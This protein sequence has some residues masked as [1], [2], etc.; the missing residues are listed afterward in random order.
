MVQ[1]T[2]EVE[3]KKKESSHGRK[4]MMYWNA[5]QLGNA[6]TLAQEAVEKELQEGRVYRYMNAGF[7]AE[8]SDNDAGGLF[9]FLHG[10]DFDTSALGLNRKEN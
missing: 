8:G 10:V 6:H 1:A 3:R 5:K 2:G 4:T 9:R 7:Q